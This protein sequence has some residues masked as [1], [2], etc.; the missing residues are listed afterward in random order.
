MRDYESLGNAIIQELVNI[1]KDFQFEIRKLG[2]RLEKCLN[3]QAASVNTESLTISNNSTVGHQPESSQFPENSNSILDSS[4]WVKAEIPDLEPSKSAKKL[5]KDD[6]N[7]VQNEDLPK[8]SVCNETPNQQ[9]I[10]LNL[11]CKDTFQ[12][13]EKELLRS[14]P[15]ALQNVDIFPTPSNLL[16]SPLLLDAAIFI[17]PSKSLEVTEN[18]TCRNTPQ[19]LRH[20]EGQIATK[21]KAR[22]SSYKRPL[23]QCNI[24]NKF[25]KK[26]QF[27]IHLA[28]HSGFKSNTCAVCG[29]PFSSRFNL[30]SHMCLHTGIY[31]F[32]CQTCGKKFVRRDRMIKHMLIK[33]K[34][35]MLNHEKN[36]IV[37]NKIN[38][39]P[40]P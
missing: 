19:P 16:K 22:N 29:K 11:V 6:E 3:L 23:I 36:R 18:N 26:N 17:E 4:G 13:E 24:C 34:H 2:D 38:L 25:I 7:I 1:R 30:D 35:D 39:R 31:P 33:H 9:N 40:F 10:D 32:A 8:S 21:V 14:L 27:N 28:T 20:P 15:N 5:F 37:V 12:C